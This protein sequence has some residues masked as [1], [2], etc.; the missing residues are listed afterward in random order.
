MISRPIFAVTLAVALATT[1]RGTER[2][3][4][5]G[6]ARLLVIPASDR[7]DDGL[8]CANGI[9]A[10]G[11]VVLN[12]GRLIA[13]GK[14]PVPLEIECR[15]RAG[16]AKIELRSAAGTITLNAGEGD[17]G[18]DVLRLDGGPVSG[19]RVAGG[20][21]LPAER[22]VT[23]RQVVLDD[24]MALFVDGRHRAD[25][26]AGFRGLDGRVEIAA[27][28]AQVSIESMHVRSLPAGRSIEAEIDP[29]TR[30]ARSVP[31]GAAAGGLHA[32]GECDPKTGDAREVVAPF[33]VTRD[34]RLDLFMI[35]G[36]VS[37]YSQMVMVWG[38]TRAGKDTIFVRQ[39]AR[40]LEVGTWG[41]PDAYA[42]A[43]LPEDRLKDWI[44]ISVRFDAG[45]RRLYLSIDG[46]PAAD[47]PCG[48]IFFDR[49][50]PVCLGQA[51]HGDQMFSGRLRDVVLENR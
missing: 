28:G 31:G 19:C 43:M 17:G 26:N 30:L 15:V 37:N 47:C 8:L 34:W 11:A 14:H 20:G 48:A 44:P 51:F 13:D 10:D 3:A 36:D 33:D 32:F 23:I 35:A 4:E 16:L 25:W 7:F 6:P 42:T 21:R 45:K 46:K 27:S 2:L 50:M 9:L 41:E 12:D 24:G 29:M 22:V 49:P 38:D 1:S 5:D 40:S 39:R 18:A